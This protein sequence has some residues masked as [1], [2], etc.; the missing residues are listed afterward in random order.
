MSDMTSH[1]YGPYT[2]RDDPKFILRY[3]DGQELHIKS[4]RVLAN[5]QVVTMQLNAEGTVYFLSVHKDPETE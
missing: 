4:V 2:L 5:G 1:I 3:A